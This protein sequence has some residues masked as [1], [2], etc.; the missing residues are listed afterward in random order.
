MATTDNSMHFSGT[1]SVIKPFGGKHRRSEYEAQKLNYL[2]NLK[3]QDLGVGIT[4]E[5]ST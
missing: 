5:M 3:G 4:V 2:Y 1:L